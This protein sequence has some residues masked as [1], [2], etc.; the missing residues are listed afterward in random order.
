MELK[1]SGLFWLSFSGI[2]T[3][4]LVYRK[5]FTRQWLDHIEIWCDDTWPGITTVDSV[6]GST[7]ISYPSRTLYYT[8]ISLVLYFFPIVIMSFAYSFIIAKLWSNRQPGEFT[9]NRT[10]AQEKIKRKVCHHHGE[11][12]RRGT[13]YC[14]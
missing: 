7:S 8:F 6:T 3:P 12:K 10:S 9:D 11:Q 5:Q 4:L 13:M 1:S 14:T 2:S